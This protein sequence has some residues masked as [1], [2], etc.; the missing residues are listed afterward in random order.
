MLNTKPGKL[1]SIYSSLKANE[2]HFK[3]YKKDE[4]PERYHLKNHRR[5]P[6]LI[7]V[8][9]LGYTINIKDFFEKH[10]DYPQGGTHGFDNNEKE[11]WALFISSGPDF[12]K[13]IKMPAFENIH[14]YEVMS[15]VL[16][17]TP[18]PNDG[19]LDS[20]KIMLQ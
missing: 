1:E 7:L 19:S 8:A 18:A 12:K 11:M 9:D 3:V 4:L 6:E 2:N 16:G 10:P 14:L 15:H 13:G 5:I 20:V 17:L